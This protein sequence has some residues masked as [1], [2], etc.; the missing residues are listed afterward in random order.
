MG[1]KIL[2]VDDEPLIVDE[3][4]ETLNDEGYD[5]FSA[6]NVNDAIDI[7]RNN[8]DIDLILTDLNMPGKSGLDF[9]SIMEAEFNHKFT[10]IVMSGH[11]SSDVESAITAQGFNF[12]RK[13]IDVDYLVDTV[14]SKLK[15]KVK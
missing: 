12:L 2:I 14:N 10:F 15:R 1:I 7:A 6:N 9:I 13:P 5:C 3:V 8:S 11:G 4:K